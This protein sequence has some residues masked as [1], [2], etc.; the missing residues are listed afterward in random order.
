[1][2]ILLSSLERLPAEQMPPLDLKLQWIGDVQITESTNKEHHGMAYVDDVILEP[3]Y[4]VH[5][6]QNP[7]VDKAMREMFAEDE[8]GV[9]ISCVCE[10][11][12]GIPGTV[13]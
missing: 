2:G 8:D 4:K 5:N 13:A 6:F 11:M 12:R 10:D 9:G 1:M 7:K 3:H